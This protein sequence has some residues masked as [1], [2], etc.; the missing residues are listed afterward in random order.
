M[1][2][3]F[4]P[5]V[6]DVESFCVDGAST[7]RDAIRLSQEMDTSSELISIRALIRSCVLTDFRWAGDQCVLSFG[8]ASIMLRADLGRLFLSLSD[9]NSYPLDSFPNLDS[10]FLLRFRGERS[11]EVD[12]SPNSELSKCHGHELTRINKS[13]FGYWIKFRR[14]ES[15][16]FSALR[17]VSSTIAI[18]KTIIYFA[19]A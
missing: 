14:S 6:I 5:P 18:P 16:L 1:N 7:A 15:I 9:S 2:S 12:W 3:Q 4:A 19:H 8:K 10:R 17:V 13:D 11:I